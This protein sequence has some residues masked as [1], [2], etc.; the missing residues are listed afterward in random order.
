MTPEREQRQRPLGRSASGSSPEA[1][2]RGRELVGLGGSIAESHGGTLDVQS[3]PGA[4]AAFTVR[5][6]VA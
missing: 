3:Q 6:P 2:L 1:G 5:L 4:V